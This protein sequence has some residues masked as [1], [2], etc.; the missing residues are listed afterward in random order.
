MAEL[1]INCINVFLIFFAAGYFLSGMISGK[2]NQRKSKIAERIESA[3]SHKKEALL[4]REDYERRIETFETERQAIM[5]KAQ[6]RA[7]MTENHILNEAEAEAGRILERANREAELKKAKVKDEIKMDI[8]HVSERL[9]EKLI[10]EGVDASKQ[11]EWISGM[12]EE[13]GAKTWE[14]L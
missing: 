5:S 8:I 9:A 3:K 12:L 4:S 10:A 7:K 11:D 6:E 1:I 14:S 2:L 13:M